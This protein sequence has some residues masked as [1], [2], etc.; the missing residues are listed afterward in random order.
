MLNRKGG[1]IEEYRILDVGGLSIE[2]REEIA[3]VMRLLQEEQGSKSDKDT[4]VAWK[5]RRRERRRGS[6]RKETEPQG[7]GREFVGRT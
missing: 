3:T 6:R 2:D 4:V 7:A 1:K 5:K